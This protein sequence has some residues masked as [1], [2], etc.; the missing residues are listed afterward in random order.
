MEQTTTERR[1]SEYEARR[2]EPKA[3][4][5]LEVPTEARTSK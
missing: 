5:S 1:T 2:D 4:R 3:G